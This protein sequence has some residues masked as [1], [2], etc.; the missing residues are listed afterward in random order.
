MFMIDSIKKIVILLFQLDD[1][2][3]TNSAEFEHFIYNKL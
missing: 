2:L 3:E 1:E